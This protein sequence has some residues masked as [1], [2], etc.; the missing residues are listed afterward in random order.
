MK[1]GYYEYSDL[2]S[3]YRSQAK[4][5]LCENCDPTRTRT[6]FNGKITNYCKAHRDY[7]KMDK[8]VCPDVLISKNNYARLGSYRPSGFGCYITT[9][10]CEI[11]GYEDDCEVLSVMREFRDTYLKIG[12]IPVLL[13]YDQIGPVISEYLRCD[14][15]RERVALEAMQKYLLPCTIAYK[16]G[17]PEKAL[18][19]YLAMIAELK[20]KYGLEEFEIDVTVPYDIDT[21]GKGRIRK[22]S[23]N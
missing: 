22:P 8:N 7:V 18:N 17:N 15:E 20:R 11:L 2:P 23:E 13:E 19:I 10:V 16:N 3:S 5:G 1:N 4:C 14:Q 21:V 12:H 9:I 6:D